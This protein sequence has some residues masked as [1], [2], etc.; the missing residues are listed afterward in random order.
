[1]RINTI[2]A[3][4]VSDSWKGVRLHEIALRQGDLD[5]ACGPYSLMM[6]LL[7]SGGLN[8]SQAMKL[9]N[10]EVDGRSKFAKWTKNLDAML[11][12]GTT[13]KDLKGLFSAI[14]TLVKTTKI[15]NLGMVNVPLGNKTGT[16]TSKSALAAVRQ[17]ID[18]CDKPVILI[19]D[20]SKTK[21]HWVVAVGYQV[22]LNKNGDEE[23]AHILTLDPDSSIGKT[24][25]WNGVLGLGALTDK[26]LR[27]MTEDS[28]QAVCSVR[29]AIGLKGNTRNV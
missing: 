23:L 27:Y 12:K 4:S 18:D 19:L 21:A 26:K 14:Q 16:I 15:Q 8:L 7:L 28:D 5:G 6:A 25:A 11:T 24:S 10:G 9:W 29:E 13:D 20:W 3:I 17:Y 2:S 22:R 1:M